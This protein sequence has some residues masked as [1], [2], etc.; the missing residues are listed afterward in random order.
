MIILKKPIDLLIKH[1]QL[2]AAN[3]AKK[4]LGQDVLI[5]AEFISE[6]FFLTII[7]AGHLALLFLSNS[8]KIINKFNSEKD[9]ILMFMEARFCSVSQLF[10]G[11][12]FFKNFYLTGV[13][14]VFLTCTLKSIFSFENQRTLN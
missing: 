10:N 11:S 8:R 2:F 13:L 12:T 9:I 14:N 1:G 5:F 3:V 4:F 6:N 7:D